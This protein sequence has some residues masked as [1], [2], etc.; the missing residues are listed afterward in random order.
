MLV[1]PHL[2]ET[3]K[4]TVRQDIQAD[5]AKLELSTLLIYGA[6][7]TATPVESIGKRLQRQISLSKLEVIEGADH[8]VHQTAAD[9]VTGL[10]KE[11]LK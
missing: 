5:A 7:D 11:F 10:V 2:Q 4:R 1:V 3:F 8:F 6:E 9:R